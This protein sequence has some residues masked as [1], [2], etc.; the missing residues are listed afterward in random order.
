MI[1]GLRR[2]A[3]ENCPLLDYCAAIS[4]T[5]LE[6]FRDDLSVPSSGFI[7]ILQKVLG[8]AVREWFDNFIL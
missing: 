2:E 6:T 5:F 8:G 4:C 3:D 1:S 7:K